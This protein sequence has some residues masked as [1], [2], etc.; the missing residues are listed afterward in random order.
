MSGFAAIINLLIYFYSAAK[1]ST[2]KDSI[3][4]S[5]ASSSFQMLGQ[6]LLVK[7]YAFKT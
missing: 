1:T 5:N 7:D 4:L 6:T 3:L 2:S